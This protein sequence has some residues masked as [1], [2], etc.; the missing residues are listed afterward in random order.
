MHSMRFLIGSAI[1]AASALAVLGQSTSPCLEST[2]AYTNSGGFDPAD[3]AASGATGGLEIDQTIF[4]DPGGAINTENIVFPKTQP[5]VADYIGEGAGASHLFGFFFM[6]IDSSGNGIPNFYLIGENDDLDGDGLPNKEDLDDDGDGIPDLVDKAGYNVS[7]GP[8]AGWAP[9]LAESMPADIFRNGPEAAAA[10][11]HAN[12]YWQYVPNGVESYTDV[13]GQTFTRFFKHPGAYLYVDQYDGNGNSGQDQI[14]DMMQLRRGINQVPAFCLDKDWTTTGASGSTVPGLLGKWG[15][16]GHWIGSTIF[17]LADD[18][19]GTGTDGNYN[20]HYPYRSGGTPIIRDV[21]GS[22]DSWPDYDL[23]GTTDPSDAAVPDLVKGD[24][25]E[26]RALWRYR[27]YESDIS[28][29]REMAFF[30]VVFYGSGG[31]GVNTYFSKSGFN[32]DNVGSPN[33]SGGANSSGDH[34]GVARP[35]DALGT[36]TPNNWWPRYQNEGDHDRVAAAAFGDGT[37]WS[38]IVQMPYTGGAPQAIDPDNQAWV[39][40]YENYNPL[41]RV[42]AYRALEDWLNTAGT[43]E[44]RIQGRYD[45]DLDLEGESAIIRAINGRMN[46]LM[47]G[48]PSS[49][50]NA[51][52]LGWEDLF[53]GGDRDYEDIVWYISRQAS[54]SVESNNIAQGLNAFEDVSLTQVRFVFT[55]NFTD[56][57]FFDGL[58]RA[59]YIN[60]YYKLSIDSEWLPLIGSEWERTPDLFASSGSVSESGGKVTREIT[61][62]IPPSEAGQREI[63]WKVEMSTGDVGFRPELFDA[64][65]SYKALAHDFYYETA[66]IPSSNVDYYGSYETPSVQWADQSM[67]RG[68]FYALKTFEHSS[69]PERIPIELGVNPET[70][71]D[72]EVAPYNYSL[73][74]PWLWDAGLSLY[75]QV[76]VD[77]SNRRI[78]TFT[79][80]GGSLTRHDFSLDPHLNS[81]VQAA[82]KLDDPS[83]VG[84][85][86]IDGQV[87]NNFHDP[88]YGA[89][90]VEEASAWLAAWVHGYNGGVLAGNETIPNSKKEWILGGVKHSS[91]TIVRAPGQPYWF[92]GRGM[93]DP[94]DVN[95]PIHDSYLEFAE[96]QS[97]IPTRVIFGSE[98]GMVHSVDAG[99]WVFDRRAGDDI[100]F[101]GHYQED[102]V[103]GAC[104]DPV[105]TTADRANLD[106]TIGTGEEMWAFIP[107]NLLDDLKY[108]VTGLEPNGARASVDSTGVTAVVYDSTASD[109]WRRVLIYSQGIDSGIDNGRLGSYTWALDITDVDDPQPLWE[110]TQDN[111]Q[112]LLNPPAVAWTKVSGSLKWVV[113]VSSGGSPVAGERPSMVL[114]DALT[115]QKA[116]ESDLGAGA[117]ETITGTPAFVDLDKDGLIDL[118]FGATS[119]GRIGAFN[120][121]TGQEWS[122]SFNNA[123][124][125]VAPNVRGIDDTKVR[126]VAVSGDSPILQDEDVN[127]ASPATIYVLTFDSSAGGGSAFVT[128]STFSLPSKQKVFARPRLVGENLVLGTTSGD[129][130]H[131]CD[132]DPDDPGN[133]YV[134]Q[135]VTDIANAPLVEDSTV[136]S[137]YGSIKGPITV[138]G[139]V[140][141]AHKFVVRNQ[142]GGGVSVQE[143]EERSPWRTDHEYLGSREEPSR[144]STG[145]TFGITGWHEW[146]IDRF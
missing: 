102:D 121:Q 90:Q 124:F 13:N 59:T 35:G 34:Y 110:Y 16:D 12:D 18:D 112:N 143:E 127:L 48:A 22:T 125:F 23:Y 108:N 133:L 70:V 118:A 144:I 93:E 96:K 75:R 128:E 39:D 25:Q 11:E 65:V 55:D 98:S 30:M 37:D 61:I 95:S 28:G 41:R 47:V 10:G 136:I 31:Q 53:G 89:V 88:S 105:D 5:F 58:P 56:N 8:E 115:G 67:N 71:S 100:Y 78:Y 52:L 140:I 9:S 82:L 77:A 6:D 86:V 139:G 43:A 32:P 87:A 2:K 14:P 122:S 45:I 46:H 64:E 74:I 26:G 76:G 94:G 66:V 126:V 97:Q 29:G 99:T 104:S 15:D 24:D 79:G 80:T 1:L 3:F 21:Y 81:T 73:P 146:L 72:G 19:G 130:V 113:G 138:V 123:H 42:I 91:A 106:Y 60:Y 83:D 36:V 137:K 117:G 20:N 33:P 134:F 111:F 84:A 107:G 142:N 92:P 114:I 49:D 4:A 38:D 54:G 27:W 119:D 44:A 69:A 129:T 51:W 50:P 145:K 141:R 131:L 7:S 109:D 63:Y 103:C 116:A 135:D 40:R 132:F 17:Y 62:D 101:D 57:K 85:T 120:P 68:H